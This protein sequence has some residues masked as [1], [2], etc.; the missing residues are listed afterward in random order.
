MRALR[1]LLITVILLGLLAVAAVVFW[2][3]RWRDR[4]LLERRWFLRFAASAGVLAVVAMEAGWIATEVGRQPWTVYGHLRTLD[5]VN[6]APGLWT[7]LALVFLVY[8]L[9]TVAVVAVMRRLPRVPERAP[10][11]PQ[12]SA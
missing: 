9:M 1:N 5:A 3:A 10:V 7:G 8:A 2:V 6:P 4:D 11:A 12:E